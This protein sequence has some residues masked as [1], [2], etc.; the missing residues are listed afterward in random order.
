MRDEHFRLAPL[1]LFRALGTRC[2]F[3]RFSDPFAQISRADYRLHFFCLIFDWLVCCYQSG[4]CSLI[5][6]KQVLSVIA[7]IGNCHFSSHR[8]RPNYGL[9]RKSH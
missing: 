9:G 6:E 3:S 8:I 4:R 5:I 1:L 7:S 2:T